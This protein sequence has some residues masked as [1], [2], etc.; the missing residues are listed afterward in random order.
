LGERNA[1]P[2]MP[3]R[4]SELMRTLRAMQVQNGMILVQQQRILELLQKKR[5]AK[6]PEE[7][8]TEEQTAARLKISTTQFRRAAADLIANHGLQRMRIGERRMYRAGSLEELIRTLARD[9]AKV[10]IDYSA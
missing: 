3:P 4:D 1:P 5:K 9:D 8:L 6:D 2:G 7:L 10:K